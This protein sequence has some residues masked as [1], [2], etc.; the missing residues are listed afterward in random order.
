MFKCILMTDIWIILSDIPC[1]IR[2]EAITWIN[3][4]PN[5]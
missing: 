5:P 3:F 4:E 1:D 2:Q